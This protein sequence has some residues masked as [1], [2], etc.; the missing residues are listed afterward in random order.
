MEKCRHCGGPSGTSIICGGCLRTVLS[1]KYM[2]RKY[3]RIFQELV[4]ERG[5]HV[6]SYCL[7]DFSR[8]SRRS[9]ICADHI[10]TKG[11][12]PRLRY[13]LTNARI[14]C[15]AGGN[16]CHNRRGNGELNAL[17]PSAH[18]LRRSDRVISSSTRLK[19]GRRTCRHRGCPLLPFE[20][21]RCVQHRDE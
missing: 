3:D 15:G 9:L 21:G 19:S 4:C 6:C 2:R 17:D 13:D 10:R 11:G 20:D 16:D 5:R 14:A 1:S 18:S 7:E 8:S 12:H